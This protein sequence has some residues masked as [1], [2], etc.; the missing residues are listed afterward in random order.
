VLIRVFGPS[1]AAKDEARDWLAAAVERSG[2]RL[3]RRPSHA[4]L[5]VGTPEAASLSYSGSFAAAAY[6]AGPVGIDIECSSR[7]GI[8]EWGRRFLSAGELQSPPIEDAEYLKLWT[9]KEAVL[10]ALGT[11]LAVDPRRVEAT[12]AVPR[13]DGR[14]LP[15]LRIMTR[16]NSTYVLSVCSSTTGAVGHAASRTAASEERKESAAD[17]RSDAERLSDLAESKKQDRKQD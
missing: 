3:I 11:G 7:P 4:P 9:R 8:R 2:G 10:K 6:G 13:L 15:F 14:P 17:A 12:G 5:C 16:R 1:E